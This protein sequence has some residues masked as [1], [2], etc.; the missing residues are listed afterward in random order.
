MADKDTIDTTPA[1]DTSDSDTPDTSAQ[2]SVSTDSNY[3]YSLINRK[4]P[5][6][7]TNTMNN[8][9]KKAKKIYDKVN[10]NT[11][12]DPNTPSADTPNASAQ[13]S[14]SNDSNS[15]YSSRNIN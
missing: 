11:T 9:K 3:P 8:Q 6:H 7:S 4:F 13:G 5:P 10:I 14:V 1:P 15:P 12:P 2:D